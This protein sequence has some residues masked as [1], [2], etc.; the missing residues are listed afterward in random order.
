MSSEISEISIENIEKVLKYLPYFEDANNTFFH[1]SKE[2]SLDPYIYNIKVQEFIKILYSGNFIQSFD[3]I[4]WQD[5]AEKFATDE[6]LLKNA[7]LTTIIKLFTT[8]I[9]KERFCSGHLACMIGSGHILQLLKRLKTIRKE[10][11]GD[12]MDKPTNRKEPIIKRFFSPDIFEALTVK[13]D[14][15]FMIDKII[16]SGFEYDMQIREDYFNLYYKGNSLAKVMCKYARESKYEV[17]INKSFYED[18]FLDND[19]LKRFTGKITPMGDYISIKITNELLHPLF[20]DKYLAE[21]TSR[22][23]ERQYQEEIAFEHM[24]ITD[25]TDRQDLIIIDRQIMDSMDRTMRMDLLA[26]RQIMGNDYQFCVVEV[27][28]GNNPELQG[29]VIKQLKGYVDRISVN[30][31]DYKYCYELN[32]KQKQGLGLYESQDKIKSLIIN[33]INGV[34]GIIVVSGY[35]GKAKKRIEEL[36]Q[37]SPDINILPLWNKIDFSKEI[38]KNT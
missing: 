18:N 35:S 31:D 30:F 16:K 37:K 15:K 13:Q 28:L 21:F 26:L 17:R 6:H 2:S 25:N 33:I 5:E 14:F 36:R 27:K 34:S 23:K 22:I 32:F 11:K 7:D 20:Q 4:A 9:R 8:H 24:L 38:L 10:L 19:P 29:D 1:L 12:V 3:W